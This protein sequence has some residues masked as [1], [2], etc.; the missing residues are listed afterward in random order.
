M[1]ET[2]LQATRAGAATPSSA[3]TPNAHSADQNDS[4]NTATARLRVEL[5]EALRSKGALDARLKVAE[6]EL[7]RLR[8]KTSTETRTIDSLA[9]DRKALSRKLR[10][11]EE[12]LVAK[13]KLVADVQ[14]EL[15]VLHLQ[16]NMMEKKHTEKVNENKQLVARFME[17][18]GL[19]A[20]KM[21]ETSEP[22]FTKTK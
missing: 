5:A 2:E 1:L 16:L 12:E 6:E 8:A 11:R 17:R 13:K 7:V 20:D 15:S 9:A 4:D 19:E 22:F 21:N 10:D 3:K 14:D 18:V